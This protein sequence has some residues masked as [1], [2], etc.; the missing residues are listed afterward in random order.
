MPRGGE[1]RELLVPVPVPWQPEV[2]VRAT[3]GS[4]G[5]TGGVPE[6]GNRGRDFRL[7]M[8]CFPSMPIGSALA[9]RRA[10]LLLAEEDPGRRL[11]L[12]AVLGRHYDLDVA[13]AS[14]DLIGLTDGRWPDL[15]V[16]GT[17]FQGGG[18]SVLRKLLQHPKTQ[19]IPVVLVSFRLDPSESSLFL[20]MGAFDVISS[21][22]NECE[23]VARIEHALRRSRERARLVSLAQTDAMTG[24]ANFGAFTRRLDDEFKS[25]QRYRYALSL[26]MV[27]LD[28]L[29]K[30]NDTLGHEAGNQAILALSAL[31][32]A[33]LRQTD[34]AARYGGDEFAAILPHQTPEEARVWLDRLRSALAA[35]AQLTLSAG[36]AGH[37]VQFPKKTP[38]DLIRAADHALYAAKSCGRDAVVVYDEPI[39]AQH[40]AHAPLQ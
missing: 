30:I 3:V 35:E 25:A 32:A 1:A 26:A 24:L 15:V 12:A 13:Q 14:D 19:E 31:L 2:R 40:G 16:L 38:S 28:H 9:N 22:Q 4:A 34:F 8:G 7:A 33:N 27:D 11:S 10:R 5:A 17:S 36:I 23:L 18:A 29:K 6:A 37:A 20:G 39:G 21:P